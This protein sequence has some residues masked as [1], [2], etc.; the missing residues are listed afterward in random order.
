V[1]LWAVEVTVSSGTIYGGPPLDSG[2]WFTRSHTASFMSIGSSGS[3]GSSPGD[4]LYRERIPAVSP[5]PTL[6][7]SESPVLIEGYIVCSSHQVS[8]SV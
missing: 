8:V 2:A 6:R 7:L 3:D 1:P 5:T 4:Q